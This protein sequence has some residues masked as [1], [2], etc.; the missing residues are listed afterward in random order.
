MKRA[1]LLIGIQV[2]CISV[3]AAG[4]SIVALGIALELRRSIR[5]HYFDQVYMIANLIA[6]YTACIFGGTSECERSGDA[7]IR[8]TDSVVFCTSQSSLRLPL[9]PSNS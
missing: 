5:H 4:F 2:G 9:V 8:L 1:V 6:A 3:A 7:Q